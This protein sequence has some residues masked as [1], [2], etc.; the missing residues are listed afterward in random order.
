MG[1]IGGAGLRILSGGCQMRDGL[2][3]TLGNW[4]GLLQQSLFPSGVCEIA[5]TWR[6]LAQGLHSVAVSRPERTR[7]PVNGGSEGASLF[8]GVLPSNA[9]ISVVH[10]FDTVILFYHELL[11]APFCC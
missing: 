3:T 4:E 7:L 1:L 10:E 6:N 9:Q 8:D 5:C 11:Y 2:P